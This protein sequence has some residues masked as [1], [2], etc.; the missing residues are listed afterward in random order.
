MLPNPLVL[1]ALLVLS[2]G[3]AAEASSCPR[4]AGQFQPL[5]TQLSGTCGEITDPLRIAIDDVPQPVQTS[6]VTYPN[7]RLTTEV[8]RRGC[9][10]RMTQL[11]ESPA[12]GQPQSYLTGEEL[13]VLSANEMVGQVQMTRYDLNRNPTCWGVYDARLL[14][15]TQTVGA[16]VNGA[17][18][19]R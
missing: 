14:K 7:G 3:C 16:A 17:T 5:Y 8:Q 12:A 2:A 15:E 10:V 9:S 19:A 13:S 18:G 1:I 6:I 11:F 4:V